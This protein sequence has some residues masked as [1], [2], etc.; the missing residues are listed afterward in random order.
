M[1]GN[2]NPASTRQQALLPCGGGGACHKCCRQQRAPDAVLPFAP[3]LYLCASGAKAGAKCDSDDD[4]GQ[5]GSGV[6]RG[7]CPAIGFRPAG[8]N[9]THDGDEGLRAPE[10]RA[11]GGD[12]PSRR[13][14]CS[15]LAL[16]LHCRAG[17]CARAPLSPLPAPGA[18]VC[19]HSDYQWA[20]SGKCWLCPEALTSGLA[21]PLVRLALGLLLAPHLT[22]HA[23]P[24]PA[25]AAAC[26]GLWM[27][28]E[29]MR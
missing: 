26:P 25:A 4:C 2:P 28:V 1:R 16:S 17:S 7:Y 11:Y 3:L 13:W 15:S 23:R 12:R 22:P 8:A 27:W 21:D 14:Q 18:D 20:D 6:C 10:Q 5:G 29:K 9:S 24:A 19:M